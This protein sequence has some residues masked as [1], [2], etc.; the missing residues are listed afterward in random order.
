MHKV[1]DKYNKLKKKYPNVAE[2]MMMMFFEKMGDVAYDA[3]EEYEIEKEYGCHIGTEE[4]Y[5]KS[6]NLLE[7]AGD[8]GEGAKWKNIDD[9]VKLSGIDFETKDYTEYD[10]AYVLNSLY[11][12]YCNVFTE[13]S[14]YLKMAKNYLEDNDPADKKDPSERA[15]RDAK[16]RIKNYY[17]K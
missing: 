12:D 8:K 16:E 5:E 6:V 10:Y 7:W 14:Y 4:F 1:V 2:D 3:L 11:A 15:Y 17:E 9:I 13:S